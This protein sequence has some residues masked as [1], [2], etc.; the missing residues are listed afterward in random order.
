MGEGMIRGTHAAHIGKK[1]NV[2]I[3][4]GKLE[5]KTPIGKVGKDWDG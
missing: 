5:R 4:V 1:R 3:L 2:Q